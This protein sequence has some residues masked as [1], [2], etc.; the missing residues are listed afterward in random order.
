MIFTIF[1][2]LFFIADQN[3]LEL[4]MNDELYLITFGSLECKNIKNYLI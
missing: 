3:L 2:N 1:K 4:L